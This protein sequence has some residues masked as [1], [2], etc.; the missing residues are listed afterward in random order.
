MYKRKL[1]EEGANCITE[2]VKGGRSKM[3]NRESERR[4]EQNV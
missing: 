3:Y 1:E 2:K 4:K